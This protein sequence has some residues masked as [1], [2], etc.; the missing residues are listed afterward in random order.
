MFESKLIVYLG[1]GKIWKINT[2]EQTKVELKLA[3][4]ENN[5]AI[6]D[7]KKQRDNAFL[8]YNEN[9]SLQSVQ[10]QDLNFRKKA[11]KQGFLCPYCLKLFLTRQAI[12]RD[13]IDL[14]LGP[15]VC[16]VCQVFLKYE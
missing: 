15:V 12:N 3:K 7:I 4:S 16:D 8:F 13:H 10:F 6:S 9:F 14:H 1:D 5:A 2:G 11:T